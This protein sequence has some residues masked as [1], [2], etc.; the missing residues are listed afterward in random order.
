MKLGLKKC[1]LMLASPAPGTSQPD[2][3]AE[4]D[5]DPDA[6][7]EGSSSSSSSSSD[8]GSLGD[9][10]DSGDTGSGGSSSGGGDNGG[11]SASGQVPAAGGRIVLNVA[12][13][14][15][16]VMCAHYNASSGRWVQGPGPFGEQRFVLCGWMGWG[17]GEQWEQW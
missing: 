11:G 17:E 3:T 4:P 9:L 8:P 13:D 12:A 16:A 10:G 14:M 1:G 2:S 5:G 7:T 15:G 6:G